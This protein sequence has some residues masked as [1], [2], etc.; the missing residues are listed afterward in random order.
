LLRA[1]K[2]DEAK[3]QLTAA[4]KIAPENQELRTALEQAS[5]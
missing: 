5:C 2:R 3:A 1:G 4:L